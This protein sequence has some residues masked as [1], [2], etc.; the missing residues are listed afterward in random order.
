MGSS[1]CAVVA[2]LEQVDA[3]YRL[4]TTYP[5]VFGFAATADELERVWSEVA[6][7]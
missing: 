2:T 7:R 5:Q 3:V 4:V 1:E 6:A